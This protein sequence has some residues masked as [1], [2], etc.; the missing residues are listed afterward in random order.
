MNDLIRRSDLYNEKPEWLN[1]LCEGYEEYNNGWN[2]C[3]EYWLGI[4]AEL[5]TAYDVSE[6]IE[7]LC[8]C[9]STVDYII[10]NDDGIYS[11]DYYKGALYAYKDAIDIARRGV[12]PTFVSERGEQNE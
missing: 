11:L 5:P 3:N 12:F 9:E 7:M 10:D 4:I 1:P 8:R 2:D 6:V